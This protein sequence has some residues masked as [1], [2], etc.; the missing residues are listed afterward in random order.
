[1]Y[2]QQ[3]EEK[4]SKNMCANLQIDKMGWVELLK[5]YFKITFFKG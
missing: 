5:Y 3:G 1:M 2:L 4:P